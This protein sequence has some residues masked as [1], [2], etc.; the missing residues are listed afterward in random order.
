MDYLRQL[1]EHRESWDRKVNLRREYRRFHEVIKTQL[2]PESYGEILEIGSGIGVMRDTISTCQLSDLVETRWTDR[3]ENIYDL[4][5]ASSSVSNIILFDVFHHLEFPGSALNEINRC[6]ID[7]GR[8]HI[9]DPYVSLLGLF[10]YGV[11]HDEPIGMREAIQ[12]ELP[13]P[14]RQEFP[15]RYYAAQGNATRLFFGRK[16]SLQ[17]DT[18]RVVLKKRMSAIAYLGTGGFS[19]PA[20]VPE[21]S[22]PLLESLEPLLDCLPSCF[23][24]RCYVV[25]EKKEKE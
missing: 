19:K 5:C 10:V 25:M 24:T 16:N 11:L 15:P 12:L 18:L 13:E 23:A 1:A 20:V 14:K 9:F 8:L 21:F 22:I 2:S 7:G 17:I 4:S 3:V 6:L